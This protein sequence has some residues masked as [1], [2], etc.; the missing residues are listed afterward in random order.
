MQRTE[1]KK[2]NP[3]EPKKKSQ[4][5][6]FFA[7]GGRLGSPKHQTTT[8]ETKMDSQAQAM[9]DIPE[10]LSKLKPMTLPN[11]A[12]VPKL[13]TP[14]DL[15]NAMKLAKL[16]GAPMPNFQQMEG[17]D[18]EQKAMRD[19]TLMMQQSHGQLFK[20][21]DAMMAVAGAAGGLGVGGLTMH[22]IAFGSLCGLAAGKSVE[23]GTLQTVVSGLWNSLGA[24]GKFGLILGML[25]GL[26]TGAVAVP[27]VWGLGLGTSLDFANLLAHECKKTEHRPKL[28]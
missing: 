5:Q 8:S 20:K 11:G 21:T 23:Q 3:S 12:I 24:G 1:E 15:E 7:K 9:K 17:A 13:E 16:L 14:E 26:W 2:T 10:L 22:S 25:G 4:L 19:A 18:A 27:L 28:G 6:G